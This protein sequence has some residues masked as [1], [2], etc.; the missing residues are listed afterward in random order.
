MSNADI[1]AVVLLASDYASQQAES[2]G[3]RDVPVSLDYFR[4]GVGSYAVFR[5]TDKTFYFQSSAGL[6]QAFPLPAV[7]SRDEMKI[8]GIRPWGYVD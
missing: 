5:P 7:L 4:E 1:E 6:F 8:V 3:Q 2:S